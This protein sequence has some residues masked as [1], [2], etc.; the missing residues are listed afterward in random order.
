MHTKLGYEDF[1]VKT[2]VKFHRKYGTPPT[3][4]ILV[5]PGRLVKRLFSIYKIWPELGEFLLKTLLWHEHQHLLQDLTK[6]EDLNTMEEE[7]NRLMMEKTGRP[8]IVVC[9][10]YFCL[11]VK[12]G[13]WDLTFHRKRG[14]DRGEAEKEIINF[15]EKTYPNLALSNEYDEIV[16]DVLWLDAEF[17]KH[18]K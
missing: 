13:I 1:T 18:Q 9:V 4:K 5:I 2:R 6:F 10:W 17:K 12:M 15:L 16:D 8:G 11:F 3:T 7:A 14:Q